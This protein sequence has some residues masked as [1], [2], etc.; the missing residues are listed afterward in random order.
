[1]GVDT[2][3][4]SGEY[5]SDILILRNITILQYGLHQIVMHS[6]AYIYLDS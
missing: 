6:W 3:F 4:E 2:S 1:M 5:V